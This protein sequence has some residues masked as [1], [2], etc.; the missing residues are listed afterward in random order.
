M[1]INAM[2]IFCNSFFFVCNGKCIEI[3]KVK[4]LLNNSIVSF[5]QHYNLQLLPQFPS[6]QLLPLLPM[7]IL[8]IFFK[9]LNSFFRIFEDGSI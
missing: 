2:E 3:C 1:L 4:E 8:F 9:N 6:F 7:I 5:V